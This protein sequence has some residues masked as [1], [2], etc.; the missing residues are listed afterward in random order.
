[1]RRPASL[2][3]A[4][5]RMIQTIEAG[6]VVHEALSYHMGDFRHALKGQDSEWIRQAIEREPVHVEKIVDVWLG[7]LGEYL[8][9]RDG[10]PVPAWV[11]DPSRFLPETV[12]WC[13]K[14]L[15]MAG[16]VYTPPPW[17]RRKLVCE[18][19]ELDFIR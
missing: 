7:G 12:H 5:L 18:E 14:S 17:L 1:M 15:F 10:I 9:L 2:H 13:S 8:A 3:E 11:E 4:S 19:P 16:L 6:R